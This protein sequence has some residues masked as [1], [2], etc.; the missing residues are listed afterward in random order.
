[1]T[2]LIPNRRDL[3]MSL[4][5]AALA[6]GFPLKA[7][8]QVNARLVVVGGGFGGAT[9]ARFLKALMPAAS[10]TLIEANTEYYACPFSNLV[11]AGLRDLSEQRFGYDA[12]KSQGIKVIQDYAEDVD[13]VARTVTVKSGGTFAYDKLILSPGIDFRWNAIEGYDEAAAE[14][15]P[16]AWKSGPQTAL[17][18]QKLAEMDD[19]GVLV[20]S[21]PPAP[22]RCPPGPYERAS[23]IAHYLKTQKPKSKLVILDAQD[24]FSKQPLF[25]Q[26]W[27]DLYPDQIK[28]YG[29]SDFGRVVA[30]DPSSRTLSTEFEDFRADVANVIPPQQAGAIAHRAGVADMTGWCPIDPLAFS[31]ALQPDIHVIGDA[32]IASPMPKS[33]FSA[34]LQAKLCAMQIARILSGEPAQPTTLTNT[35]YSY[36]SDRTAVSITGVYTNDGGTLHSVEG[37]GGLSPLEADPIIRENEALQAKTWFRTIT[38]QTFG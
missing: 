12:L 11:I 3:L 26:A 34:N 30:V 5:A 29:A 19:G 20:M 15:M 18:Q 22:F 35:C 23:L 37:S 21:V 4:S 14:I 16:H 25:E 28:R 38:Q 9:A 17:L 36:L 1:M 27:S 8:A 24:N 33:A 13:P 31:S 6:A 7:A 10:V 2:G 32:T